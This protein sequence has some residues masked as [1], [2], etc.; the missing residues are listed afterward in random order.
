MSGLADIIREAARR[1][2]E[3]A[4]LGSCLGNVLIGTGDREVTLSA[5]SWELRRRGYWWG[6]VLAAVVDRLPWNSPGHCE[7]AWVSHG[8]IWAKV[9]A[10]TEPLAGRL[11]GP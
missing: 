4:S 9:E 3:L 1:A 8:P 5:G 11:K 7:E 2:G 6:F 10:E